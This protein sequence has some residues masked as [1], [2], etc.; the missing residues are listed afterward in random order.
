MNIEEALKKLKKTEFKCEQCGGCCLACGY[1]LDLN[2]E[3]TKKWKRSKELVFSNFGYY[4]LADFMDILPNKSADIW[5]H[6]QTGEELFRCPFLR[7]KGPTYR[8]LIYNNFRP[9]AC[10]LYPIDQNTGEFIKV[11]S[12]FCPGVRRITTKK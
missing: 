11:V 5:F 6:P 8:C 12:D 2:P 3:E 10:R 4:H 9:H 7:K 1:T